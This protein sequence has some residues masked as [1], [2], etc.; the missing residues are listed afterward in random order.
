MAQFI[1]K[2]YFAYPQFCLSAQIDKNDIIGRGYPNYLIQLMLDGN[3][4]TSPIN[5]L[6]SLTPSLNFDPCWLF[7]TN[8]TKNH[9]IFLLRLGKKVFRRKLISQ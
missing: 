4:L 2:K 9:K 1:D 8:L 5:C 3:Y 7:I 6:I